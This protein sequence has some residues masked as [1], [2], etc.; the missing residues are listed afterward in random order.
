M[1]RVIGVTHV[2]TTH[3][4]SG[5][6]ACT[7][8]EISVVSLVASEQRHRTC[9]FCGNTWAHMQW[10]APK[11]LAP[12]DETEDFEQE[13]RDSA[14]I[15]IKVETTVWLAERA[16]NPDHLRRHQLRHSSSSLSTVSDCRPSHWG[17]DEPL[18][19]VV[20]IE[21]SLREGDHHGSTIP[22]HGQ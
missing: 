1:I 8:F 13:M 6:R 21:Q 3:F 15:L 12:G 17:Q 7:S 5:F 19:H 9:D 4:I 20:A 18:G 22:H 16:R 10:L 11:L 14:K 2:H